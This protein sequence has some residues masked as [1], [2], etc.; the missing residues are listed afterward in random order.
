MYLE[1]INKK[2]QQVQLQQDDDAKEAQHQKDIQEINKSIKDVGETISSTID[3]K[4]NKVEI[5][6]IPTSISTPDVNKVVD[7]IIKLRQEFMDKTT[8]EDVKSHNL[9]SNLLDAISKLPK[10]YAKAVEFPKEFAVN[11]QNDYTKAIKDVV[12]AVKAIK[13]DFKPSIEVKPT[14]VTVNNDFTTLE[15]KMDMIELAIKAINIVIPEQDDS[16]LLNA[17]NKTTKAI[18]SL[19]FPVPNYVLPFKST[20]GAATQIN[21]NADGSLPISNTSLPTAGNNPAI[22][23]TYS[24]NYVSTIKTTINSVDYTRTLS[25]DVTGKL[26]GV[27]EAV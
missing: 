11:N 8:P 22:T 16:T 15:K 21:L 2:R 6:N 20:T 4:S 27:S 7:E 5:L 24:G 23:L 12:D 18:N 26:T 1:E 14:D 25:Y 10:E 17:I 9:L 13:M 19:S 3:R